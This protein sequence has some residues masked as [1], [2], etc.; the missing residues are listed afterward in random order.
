MF[1]VKTVCLA[2]ALLMLLSASALAANDV[3]Y[4]F[5]KPEFAA[6]QISPDGKHLAALVP[7]EERMNVVVM[8]LATRQAQVVTAVREQD[9]S[10]FQ[11]ANNE[12]ILFQMDRDGNESLGLF[13]INIDGSKRRVLAE[14]LEAQIGSGARVIRTTFV[15][16][17][18]DADPKHILV[19]NN[20]RRATAPDV[21]KMNIYTGRKK[22]VAS[23][24][25][26]VQG[27]FTNWDGQVMGAIYQ[28]G[29]E[30][31][32]LMLDEATE[33]WQV[34]S[35][36]RMD[37]PGFSPAFLSGD[38]ETG[39]VSSYVTPDG[40]RR[41]KAAIYEFNF[42][43]RTMGELVFEHD[44]V[45]VANVVVQRGE[46]KAV[47]VA[48]ALDRPQVHW[49]DPER[50]RLQ[51]MLDEALP[52]MVN[53][54][55]SVD[56]A[57]TVAVI[58]SWSD[59]SPPTYYL[60]D[61]EQR[62]LEFLAASRPWM[63]ASTK[64]PMRA[65]R[66]EARDGRTLHGFLTVPKGSEGKKLPLIVN[67]HGGPW[68]ADQWG[69]NTE[70]Q[71]FASRGYAVIQVNFRG[72]TGFGMEHMLASRKQWGQAMQDDITDALRWAV[73]QGIADEDRVCIYGAS[74]GGYAAMAGL[75]FTPE[76]Y[77]CG[78]NYVGVTDLPTL[79]RTMPDAWESQ[80]VWME[81][82]VGDYREE[83]EFLEQWSPS[84]HANRIQAPVLMAYGEA[85]PRVSIKHH[86]I[87]AEALEAAGVPFESIVKKN[88][89]HGFT[90]QE[91]VFEYYGAVER[92]LA[93]HLQQN[94]AP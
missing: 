7:I 81:R 38:G 91:N 77:Q 85:D 49:L 39:L 83:R 61:F 30:Q 15:L 90:K 55:S 43:T 76:L 1:K 37:A 35:R 34:V 71:F 88:E 65:I 84:R 82:M 25:G 56:D 32:F 74:Y 9:I 69:F 58:T 79:F 41:D 13:A 12:R 48:W 10:S 3:S 26:N 67:P 20:E 33:E 36:G 22:T 93:Q 2:C 4:F 78:V 24:P 28:D 86:E 6:V 60:Y 29:L 70:H 92:F 94:P 87:M 73:D 18:L 19:V 57:E 68:A 47:G 72:S 59:V 16:D 40:D 50:E 46:R 66:F 80:R 89:G 52:G 64:A 51:A 21:L 31:G 23:N 42:A 54:I 27:W 8:D 11:W 5:K 17:V 14:P 45:D 63:D 62:T 44:V 75:A 53:T